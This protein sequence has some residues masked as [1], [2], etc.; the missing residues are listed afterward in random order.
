MGYEL[1][2]F[3]VT[4]YRQMFDD[5]ID[6]KLED[7]QIKSFLLSLNQQTSYPA[8]A[9]L[10]ALQSL[11]P[12]CK[13][14]ESPKQAI[15]VCGTGGDGL[16][17]LNIS[18]AVA[19][20]VAGCGI[21]VAK[22]GNRAISSKSGSADVLTELG[23]N[24][25][26][27]SAIIEEQLKKNNLCFMFAPLYHPAFKNIARIRSEIKVPTI[28]NFLGPL[29]NPANTQLQIIGTAKKSTMIPMAEVLQKTHSKKVF[30]VHGFDGMDEVT[31]ADNSF[32]VRLEN[33]KIS[34]PEI[35]NPED[36]GI[37]KSPLE[38]VKGGDA[39]YNAGK[40]MALLNGEKSA[41][42][43]IVLIN[44]ALAL[45]VAGR[46]QSIAEGMVLARQS[47]DGG[48]AQKVLEKLTNK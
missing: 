4:N 7:D 10:G 1:K 46:V 23:V 15:D 17:T 28:F 20:V 11:K 27:E 31:I 35:I 32:L 33:G 36:Y 45:M 48:Q 2:D 9:F 29:L 13:N 42:R 12:R 26:A 38:L 37:K 34:Q 6:G 43:D 16:N 21:P 18:T 41:Y 22:H 3:S 47:I 14:I 39:K 30:I 5:I 8:D 19:F 24:I 40:I 44:S 25:E